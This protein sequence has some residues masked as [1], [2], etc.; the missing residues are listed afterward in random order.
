MTEITIYTAGGAV[1]YTLRDTT[2]DFITALAAAL[3]KGEIAQA[4]TAEGSTLFIN[5]LSAAAIEIR[6]IDEDTPPGIEK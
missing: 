1:S 2:D 4:T 6:S 3:E 5:P